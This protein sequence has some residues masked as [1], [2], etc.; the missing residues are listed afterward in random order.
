MD[1]NLDVSVSVPDE[2]K[3]TPK[4]TVTIRVFGKPYA[5]IS[6]E[7]I[8]VPKRVADTLIRLKFC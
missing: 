6:G 7:E 5:L 3:V 2:S 1:K 8:K 4:L